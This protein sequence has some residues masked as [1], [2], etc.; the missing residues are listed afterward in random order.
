MPLS[1]LTLSQLERHLYAAADILR[2]SMDASDYKQFI[3][4]LLFLK[5]CSDEFDVEHERIYQKYIALGYSHEEAL[6]QANYRDNYIN[7]F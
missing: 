4:G 2:G 7:T 1:K 6:E 3:F 5:R